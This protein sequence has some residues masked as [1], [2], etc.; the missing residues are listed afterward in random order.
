MVDIDVL[1]RVA[2]ESPEDCKPS[3]ISDFLD[4]KRLLQKVTIRFILEDLYI[5]LCIWG[6]GTKDG[7]DKLV[8]VLSDLDALLELFARLE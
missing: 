6:I 8:C 7:G 5:V 4:N 1:H 2:K 3:P